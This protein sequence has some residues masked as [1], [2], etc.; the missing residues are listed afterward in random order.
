ML[1]QDVQ[2]TG[3]S[4]RVAMHGHN[5]RNSKENIMG[6]KTR[7]YTVEVAYALSLNSL[8]C[9]MEHSLWSCVS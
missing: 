5:W 1:N 3:V 9:N 6:T 8:S 7:D 4:S 2:V